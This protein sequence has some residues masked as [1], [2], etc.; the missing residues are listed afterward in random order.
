V[1]GG[2]HLPRR[3]NRFQQLI[4]LIE[5][6]LAPQGWIV[7]ESKFVTDLDDGDQVE[8]DVAIEGRPGG[9]PILIALECRDHRRTQ[10]KE[11]I[12]ELIGKYKSLPVD[13]VMAVS[14]S[15][16]TSSAKPLAEKNR[17]GLYTIEDAEKIDWESFLRG[18]EVITVTLNEP[19]H[20][21]VSIIISEMAISGQ[22]VPSFNIRETE[23]FSKGGIS[24]GTIGQLAN[25]V[26]Q[27]TE[28]QAALERTAST[29]E[30][31]II[32]ECL[33]FRL[34]PGSISLYRQSKGVAPLG[35]VIKCVAEPDSYIRTMDRIVCPALGLEIKV[36]RNLAVLKVPLQKGAYNRCLFAYGEANTQS[37][38]IRLM[39]IH[40]PDGRSYLGAWMES[41]KPLDLSGTLMVDYIDDNGQRRTE[42][43]VAEPMETVTNR[44]S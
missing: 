19:D 33:W 28:V 5:T 8:V 18:I 34:L 22:P 17:I 42:I 1:D 7:T 4:L 23:L 41:N 43:I 39:W 26:L 21:R 38:R 36:K 37:L 11:W 25:R 9:H 10:G 16:F 30:T 32:S 14:R 20:S 27:T 31:P 35:V 44:P 3:S 2:A 13:K 24:Y 15:G 29:D 6:T 40:Q 12:R